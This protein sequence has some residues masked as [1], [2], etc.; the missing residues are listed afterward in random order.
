MEAAIGYLRHHLPGA[1]IEDANL[2][3]RN[4]P[5][6]D[7]LI[8]GSYRVQVKGNTNFQTVQ[9][10]HKSLDGADLDYD[11]VLVVDIGVTLDGNDAS[12]PLTF[13]PVK[14]C[15]DIYAVPNSVV[16]NWLAEGRCVNKRGNWIH[17]YKTPSRASGQ[18]PELREYLDRPD[19][20][21]PS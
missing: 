12:K 3:R 10:S 6:F 17:F 18:I 7:V 14:T 2:K 13:A 1:T 16:R 9:F 8:D 15:A 19:L 11:L 4:Q 5:G 20:I 21:R